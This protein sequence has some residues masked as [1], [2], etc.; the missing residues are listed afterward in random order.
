MLW[1]VETGT[2]IVNSRTLLQLSDPVR[3]ME[4]KGKEVNVVEVRF[5]SFLRI[6]LH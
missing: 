6:G 3:C 5:S 2:E 4:I 1:T